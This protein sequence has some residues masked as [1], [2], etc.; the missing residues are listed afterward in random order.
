MRF[1]EGAEM[2]E[3][4]I[5]EP[6][7]RRDG[8][9]RDDAALL[10]RVEA[11]VMRLRGPEVDR[12]VPARSATAPA[13]FFVVQIEDA[14]AAR[15]VGRGWE[16]AGG[17]SLRP[18]LSCPWRPRDWAWA[19]VRTYGPVILYVYISRTVAELEAWLASLAPHGYS[20]NEGEI[21]YRIA[22][23][24]STEGWVTLTPGC[25]QFMRGYHTPTDA[26]QWIDAGLLASLV[27][28]SLGPL[29]WDLL[30]GDYRSWVAT[31]HS[32]ASLA[33]YLRADG[34]SDRQEFQT[35]LKTRTVEAS[36]LHDEVAI[37]A[38]IRESFG[39]DAETDLFEWLRDTPITELPRTVTVNLPRSLSPAY[40]NST[41]MQG[42]VRANCRVFWS[43]HFGG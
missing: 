20:R 36:G 23:S 18:H 22:A 26:L 40:E 42:L 43:F 32:A 17:Y 30:D 38:A 37:A 24:L 31:G 33:E 34:C 19:W 6:A 15:M 10:L 25:V 9:V 16:L 12:L 7:L 2:Y 27:D 29:S 28:G 3:R 21:R 5:D 39:L 13:R 35:E 14:G 4:T 1:V 11:P 8:Q 41:L